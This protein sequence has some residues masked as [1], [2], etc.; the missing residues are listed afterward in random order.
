MKSNL[1]YLFQ[2]LTGKVFSVA[3]NIWVRIILCSNYYVDE[4]EFTLEDRACG[5]FVVNTLVEG[6]ENGFI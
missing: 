5:S 1:I 2:D 4:L 6:S 3:R